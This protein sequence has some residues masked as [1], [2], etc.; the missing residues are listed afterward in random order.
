VAIL[1][2]AIQVLAGFALAIIYT[3]LRRDFGAHRSIT[4]LLFVALSLFFGGLSI[5]FGFAL[6]GI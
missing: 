1:L 5:L 4:T 2:S 6:G 3:S